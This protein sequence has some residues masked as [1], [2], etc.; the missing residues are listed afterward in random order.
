MN[1]LQATLQMQNTEKS[2][3]FHRNDI[4]ILSAMFEQLQFQQQF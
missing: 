4:Q 2:I 3:G 1:A